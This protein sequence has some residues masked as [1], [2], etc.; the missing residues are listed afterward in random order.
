MD[1]GV[2][3]A[4][5]INCVILNYNDAETVTRLVHMIHDY[6][7][8]EKIVVVD[9]KS[10]DDSWERLEILQDEK[11]AV[12]QTERNGGYGAGNNAGVRYAAKVNGATHVL[13][14]NPDVVFTENC[15]IQMSRVFLKHPDVGVVAASME[16]EVFGRGNAHNGWR[17]H[18]FVGEL[19]AMG[20]ISRRVFRPFLQY[21]ESYFRGKKAVY[22]DAVHGSM[23]MVDAKAF[24][25]CG[26]YDEGIF[27]YQEE[28]VLGWR[29]KTSG[30]R[31]VLL[32]NQTYQHEHSV[33]ISKSYESLSKRQKLR[34]EST[35]Y[36]MKHYLYINPLQQC[37]AKLWFQGILLED[38]AAAGVS[39]L[40]GKWKRPEEEMEDGRK[41]EE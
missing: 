1:E 10:S 29:M 24:C 3:N 8:L 11:V 14:A 35:L 33:T 7:Y 26:G 36:Y 16:D 31:T 19:L 34:N 25:D 32:L 13:I 9:N 5:K 12:I 40:S 17:L 22:V 15:V 38:W 41:E 18:G 4:M 20:P 30:Y 21:P 23:L 28:V 39:W 6:D 37:L 2:G 27:L